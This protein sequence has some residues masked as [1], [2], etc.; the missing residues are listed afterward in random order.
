MFKIFKSIELS[1][2][3]FKSFFK[4]AKKLKLDVSVS[5]FDEHSAKFLSKFSIDFNKLASSEI[6]N[7]KL[8]FFIK[9]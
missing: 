8:E 7:L 5:V 2:S 6:S 3:M 4:F 9:N 1:H